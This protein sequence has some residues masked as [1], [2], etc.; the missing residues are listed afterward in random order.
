METIRFIHNGWGGLS[1][2]TRFGPTTTMTRPNRGVDL[3]K[4]IAFDPSNESPTRI[5]TPLN[6]FFFPFRFSSELLIRARIRVVG[7]ADASNAL[8]P[9]GVFGHAARVIQRTTVTPSTGVW[10]YGARALSEGEGRRRDTSTAQ[11]SPWTR[12]PRPEGGL[13]GPARLASDSAG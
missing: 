8:G 7:E 1:T 3:V 6:P 4:V 12:I 10:S 2:R 13:F 11:T 5:A 9:V